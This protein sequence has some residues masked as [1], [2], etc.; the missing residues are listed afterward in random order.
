[1]RIHSSEPVEIVVLAYNNARTLPALLRSLERQTSRKIRC[2]LLDNCSNDD[3]FQLLSNWA[4]GKLG[5]EILLHCFGENTGFAQ[6]MNWALDRAK[7]DLVVLLN[8]DVVL[9]RHFMTQMSQAMELQPQWAMAGGTVLRLI[10]NRPSR[11]IDS[12]GLVLGQNRCPYD[13]HRNQR[14]RPFKPVQPF[15][16]LGPSGCCPILRLSLLRKARRDGMFFDENFGSYYED[17]DLCWR[18]RLKGLDA[19]YVPHA[20]A[21]HQREGSRREPELQRRLRIQSFRNRILCLYLNEHPRVWLRQFPFWIGF[22]LANAAR[23]LIRPYLLMAIISI[24]RQRRHWTHQRRL[25]RSGCR[26][27]LAEEKRL[28]GPSNAYFYTRFKEKWLK[29]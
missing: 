22:E 20:Y 2:S 17:V 3:S 12:L 23:I 26:L 13:W 11:I 16:F 25:A 21:W 14:H 4:K 24:L 27:T 10:K 9:S 5:D 15:P 8:G 29:R 19:G 1:M 6:A 18:A 28:F 7:T